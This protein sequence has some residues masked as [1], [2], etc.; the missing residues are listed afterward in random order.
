MTRTVDKVVTNLEIEEFESCKLKKG[1]APS[2][3]SVHGNEFVLRRD[4]RQGNLYS[5]F[6]ISYH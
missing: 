1:L 3:T 4:S 5:S 6:R 2:L